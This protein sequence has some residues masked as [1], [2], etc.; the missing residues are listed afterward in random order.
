M[1][2]LQIKIIT[3]LLLIQHIVCCPSSSPKR[4][5]TTIDYDTSSFTNRYRNGRFCIL[6]P[7]FSKHTAGIN[8]L[9]GSFLAVNH[10]NDKMRA[11]HSTY[12][13]ILPA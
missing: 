11:I 3:G 7:Q 4:E 10:H 2:L 8:V 12:H 9:G 5:E 13:I 1:K 6:W